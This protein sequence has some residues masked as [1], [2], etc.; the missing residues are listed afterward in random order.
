MAGSFK[1]LYL[2][3]KASGVRVRRRSSLPMICSTVSETTLKVQKILWEKNAGG[4]KLCRD[5]RLLRRIYLDARRHADVEVAQDVL[6]VLILGGLAQEGQK[7]S[8]FSA[9]VSHLVHM[10]EKEVV[11]LSRAELN[12]A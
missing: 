11:A 10:Q 5:V 7:S 2:S 4:T 9:A 8:G 1:A 3:L 12:A 6:A